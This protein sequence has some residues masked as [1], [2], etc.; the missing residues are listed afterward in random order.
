MRCCLKKNGDAGDIDYIC[1]SAPYSANR[2]PD[3]ATLSRAILES[4]RLNGTLWLTEMDQRPYAEECGHGHPESV[5]ELPKN[6][7]KFFTSDTPEKL[8]DELLHASI[9]QMRRNI[10]SPLF[11]GHGAWYYDHRMIQVGIETGEPKN[12][13][14]RDTF[15]KTGWWERGELQDEIKKLNDFSRHCFDGGYRPRADVLVVI[16][17]KNAFAARRYSLDL[18]D[19]PTSAYENGD[20]IGI[21]IDRS[22]GLSNSSILR[23]HFHKRSRW[24]RRGLRLRLHRG[25]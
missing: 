24:M 8:Y 15:L 1:G 25:H 5:G 11:A 22:E 19:N 18:F 16:T 23:R 4:C 9:A 17:N 3:G 20:E 21:F 14:F 6:V 10:L 12:V 13:S 7:R 2:L